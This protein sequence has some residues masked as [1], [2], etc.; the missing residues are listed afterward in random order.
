M[1]PNKLKRC[2]TCAF[3][4]GQPAFNKVLVDAGYCRIRPP[5]AVTVP[6]EKDGDPEKV[7]RG[8][9]PLVSGILDVC[10]QW[11]HYKARIYQTD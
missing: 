6:I 7:V 2:E 3:F 1:K 4:E 10:G 9:W 11:R 5:K 8:I